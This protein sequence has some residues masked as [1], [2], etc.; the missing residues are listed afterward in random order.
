M[1]LIKSCYE[2]DGGGMQRNVRRVWQTLLMRIFMISSPTITP[3]LI[4][5][6]G[7]VFP[8]LLVRGDPDTLQAKSIF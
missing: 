4:N 3:T 6:K 8:R 5:S 2:R 7:I 1:L